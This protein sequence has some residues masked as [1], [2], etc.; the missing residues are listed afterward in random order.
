M[1]A[2]S[3][4]ILCEQGATFLRVLEVTDSVGDPINYSGY[5]A[6]MQVRRRVD[7][8]DVIIELTTENGRISMNSSGQIVLSISATDTADIQTGGVYDLEIINS[9]NEVERLIQGNFTLS[10][11]VTR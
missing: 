4:D 10:L 6:R 7:S 8:D 5:T 11:E 2:G 9:S 1:S 3:Y